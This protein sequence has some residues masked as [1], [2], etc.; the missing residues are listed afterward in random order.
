MVSDQD[1]IKR[2]DFV[3]NVY[4][5]KKGFTFTDF[6]LCMLLQWTDPSLFQNGMWVSNSWEKISRIRETPNLLTCDDSSTNTMKSP[7][8]GLKKKPFGIFFFFFF[9]F[10]NFLPFFFPLHQIEKLTHV[11]VGQAWRW[12]VIC[13]QQKGAILH[14]QCITV[15]CT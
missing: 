7:L 9:F 3:E 1:V 4:I 14:A 5:Y 8:Y 12:K 11:L 15:N 6:S 10:F 2:G 13:H